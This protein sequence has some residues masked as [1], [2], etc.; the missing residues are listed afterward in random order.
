MR[1][2]RATHHRRNWLSNRDRYY[3][4]TDTGTLNFCCKFRCTD[5]QLQSTYT[6][7]IHAFQFQVDATLT[8]VSRART[9]MSGRRY[10]SSCIRSINWRVSRY[11]AELRHQCPIDHAAE[12]FFFVASTVVPIS[13][14]CPRSLSRLNC[15]HCD[16]LVY[17]G[18]WIGIVS[19]LT[20]GNACARFRSSHRQYDLQGPGSKTT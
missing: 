17:F 4:V 6:L 18:K 12:R 19:L 8:R 1:R 5:T 16:K 14:N 20:I 9:H 15:P 7:D 13:R 10:T 11:L 2:R 3:T